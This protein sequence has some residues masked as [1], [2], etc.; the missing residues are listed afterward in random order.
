[1]TRIS[2]VPVGDAAMAVFFTAFRM[3]P[4]DADIEFGLG[5]TAI[6]LPPAFLIVSLEDRGTLLGCVAMTAEEARTMANVADSIMRKSDRVTA[7]TFANLIM[8]LRAV[9]EK[10]DGVKS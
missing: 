2:Q 4:N 6:H 10:L 5:S 3:A 9:A 7:A 1:M 8:G